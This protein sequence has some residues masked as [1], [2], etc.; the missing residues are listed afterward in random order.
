MPDFSTL[1]QAL[2]PFATIPPDQMEVLRRGIRLVD[3][4]KGTVLQ[5]QGEAADWLGVLEHGLVRMFRN[6]DGRE[7]N[8][9]F[10]LDGGFTGAYEAYMQRKAA[11][12][13]VQAL[14]D[15]CVWQFDR[16]LLD[17][18]L[19]GHPCWREMSGR[20]AESELARKLDKELESRTQS[21]E[22][23]YRALVRSG[24]PLVQRVP[25]YHLASYLGIAPET[26]SRIRARS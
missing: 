17:G 3:A 15:S 4:P 26:L 2:R 25:Q 8:L 14:E 21:A 10:E 20:I 23:R 9:G 13:C 11:Q 16:G 24:S 5:R 19:A 18:L 1:Q 6:Q 12:Y 22:E 7:V